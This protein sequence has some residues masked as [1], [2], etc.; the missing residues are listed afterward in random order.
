MRTRSLG[1]VWIVLVF[2]LMNFLGCK[3]NEREQEIMH[4]IQTSKEILKSYHKKKDDLYKDARGDIRLG[5]GYFHLELSND[6]NKNSVDNFL[7]LERRFRRL[8]RIVEFIEDIEEYRERDPMQESLY[9][10]AKNTVQSIFKDS[11]QLELVK[12]Y[13]MSELKKSFINFSG[14][15]SNYR[16][17][18]EWLEP[19]SKDH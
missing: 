17:F 7:P 12:Q 19:G 8:V 5:L 6:L 4:D 1:H 10:N 11:T 3:E 14:A 18:K 16:D 13:D 9:R 15:W 2:A